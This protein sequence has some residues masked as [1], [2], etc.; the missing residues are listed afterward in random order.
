MALD[1]LQL[2]FMVVLGIEN[3][4]KVVADRSAS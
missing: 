1:Y 2:V 3:V 4:V